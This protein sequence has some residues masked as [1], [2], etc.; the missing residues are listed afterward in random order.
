[1]SLFV[2][3]LMGRHHTADLNPTLAAATTRQLVISNVSLALHCFSRAIFL[4]WP[5]VSHSLFTIHDHAIG[6]ARQ[7]L[8]T[9]GKQINSSSQL[10]HGEC[11]QI[12]GKKD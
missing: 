10:R 7:E 5:E 12:E 2:W 3:L 1:M 11:T 8:E 9:I 6:S 4:R